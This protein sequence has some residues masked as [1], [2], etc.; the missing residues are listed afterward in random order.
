MSRYAQ[1]RRR[2]GSPPTAPAAEPVTITDVIGLE[3]DMA[4]EVFFSGDVTLSGGTL[5]D[6]RF[7]IAHSASLAAA[8]QV[9][10]NTIQL[11]LGGP[12]TDDPTWQ[13][14]LAVL[15]I[16]QPQTGFPTDGVISV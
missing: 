2:G 15:W 1:R 7:R 11:D 4:V 3:G 5:N 9:A 8:T 13:W 6:G 16:D 14:D 12:F 10:P